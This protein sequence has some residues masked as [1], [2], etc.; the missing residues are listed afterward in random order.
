MVKRIGKGY[1]KVGET[2]RGKE[3]FVIK[4]SSIFSNFRE[5]GGILEI[6]RTKWYLVLS[7]FNGSRG[8]NDIVKELETKKEGVKEGKELVGKRSGRWKEPIG[9]I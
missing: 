7:W 9:R 3:I 6:K 1:Y 5:I 2:E 4:G 8:I